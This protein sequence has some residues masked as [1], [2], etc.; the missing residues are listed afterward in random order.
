MAKTRTFNQIEI[1]RIRIYPNHPETTVDEEGVPTTEY[2]P[3]KLEIIGVSKT[4]D[5]VTHRV[6]GDGTLGEKQ[7]D[8]LTHKEIYTILNNMNSALG[9]KYK[10]I[11]LAELETDVSK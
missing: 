7:A 5:G 1:K 11:I 10:E 2:Y 4:D 3:A 8:K 9:N 6:S